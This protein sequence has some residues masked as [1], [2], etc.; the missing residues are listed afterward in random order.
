MNGRIGQQLGNY[1]LIRKLGSGGFAEV[2]LG[3][4]VYLK[5]QAAIKVLPVQLTSDEIENFSHE[6]R[7]IA[8]LKHPHIISVLDFGIQESTSTPFLVMDYAPRFA[9]A[10]TA[11]ENWLD[12]GQLKA[13]VDVQE[14][15]ENIPKTFLRIFT[16]EN[17]GKQTL[18]LADPPLPVRD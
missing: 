13:Y 7:T 6:A 3:E 16:G 15:F 2:Y 9:E 18:K 14:G 5:T 8:N 10:R 17:L 4:H 11:L 12:A 1:R